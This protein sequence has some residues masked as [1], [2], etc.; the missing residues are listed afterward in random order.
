MGGGKG[1]MKSCNYIIILRKEKMKTRKTHIVTHERKLISSIPE[2]TGSYVKLIG[3][4]LI[5][6][7]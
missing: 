6:E 4:H 1:R 2:I 5:P 7:T 3:K